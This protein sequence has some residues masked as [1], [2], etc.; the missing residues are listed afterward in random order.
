MVA[1][2]RRGNETYLDPARGHVE[3]CSELLAER[4][5]GLCVILVHALKDLELSASGA[6]AVLDLVGSVGI[7][8]ANV[9]LGRVHARRDESGNAG[10]VLRLVVNVV[11]GVEMEE[12]VV[13]GGDRK[14]MVVNSVLG[15]GVGDVV[16]SG[17][18]IALVEGKIVR[19]VVVEGVG[20][21]KHL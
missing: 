6:F 12:G 19:W 11:H 10:L 17:L 2:K 15:D 20:E 18:R 3:L 13:G 9:D 14:R 5:V 1:G 4:G 16:E 21:R 7:E 8:G